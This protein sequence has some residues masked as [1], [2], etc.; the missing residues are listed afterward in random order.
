MDEV[1][2]ASRPVLRQHMKFRLDPVRDRWV[3]LG[4]ERI[5]TP[6]EEA[7]DIL[8]LCN[9]KRTVAEIA[10]VLAQTYDAPSETIE[11]DVIPLLQ[12]LADSGVLRP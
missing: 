2:R 12:G 11:A 5:L 7:V 10:E 1:T 9:G 8:Q 3:I 4:P 6:N